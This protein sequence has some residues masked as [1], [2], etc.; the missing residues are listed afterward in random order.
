VGDLRYYSDTQID[1]FGTP[2][3]RAHLAAGLALYGDNVRSESAFGSAFT[4]AQSTT[5][6]SLDRSDY[7]SALRDGAAMLALAAESR[8]APALIPSMVQLV[9][10]EQS[11]KRWTS[12]QEEAWMLLAAR[13]IKAGSEDIA[14]EVNGQP[15]LGN[16]SA[17]KTGAEVEA[18]P[19]VIANKSNE[20]LEAVLTTIAAPID[21]LP[22]GG[23]GFAIERTYYTM[24]GE[25]ANIT[26]AAQ[27]ERY[28]VVLTVTE[29]NAWPS[30]VLVSDLLPAGFQIDNPSIVGSAELTNFD[31]LGDTE[32]AHLEFRD[33][34]FI[35]AFNR[36]GSSDRE[37]RFA[38]VVRAVTPGD[39]A[40]PAASVE[41]MYRPQFSARTATGRMEVRAAQ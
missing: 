4:L 26:E 31:W 9:S 29:K 10:R 39:Y 8:P 18:A 37:F 21:P 32:A 23:D 12:T 11:V 33:D 3:A 30:R 13:A 5:G 20:P 2:L 25:E 16:F 24:D 14:L 6:K 19:I 34:R 40:H 28:V 35:A 22:A 17:R 1:Q 41:D 36:D 27:N 38:Y 15:H 7:G